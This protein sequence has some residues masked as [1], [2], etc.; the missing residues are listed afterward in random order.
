MTNEETAALSAVSFQYWRRPILENISV[1][2]H[3]GI[4]A[5]LGPNGAG[6]STL[7]SIL[8]TLRKPKSGS[9][10]VCGFDP[11]VNS[12][13]LARSRGHLGFLPQK[14]RLVPHMRVDDTLRYAAWTHGITG[15]AANDAIATV[16]A[17]LDIENLRN[18]R[19]G[20]LSGGQHQR[21]GIAATVIHSPQLLLLDEPTVG[22]DPVIRLELRHILQ[23]IAKTTA[24]V[25]STHMIEDVSFMCDNVVILDEGRIK[26]NGTPQDLES[27]VAESEWTR[28]T[29]SKLE[30]AYAA[31]LKAE[32]A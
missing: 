14:F 3:K 29:V 13:A 21:V 26:Y 4:T 10:Y 1:D 19:V 7:L 15:D 11:W 6:K 32:N 8:G 17:M 5:L 2:F 28:K 31:T 22:L 24:I 27:R 16:L 30:L 12:D 25:L 20:K 23:E 9:V 18:R